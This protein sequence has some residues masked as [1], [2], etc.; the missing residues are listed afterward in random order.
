MEQ[1]PYKLSEGQARTALLTWSL[2]WRPRAGC[3]QTLAAASGSHGHLRHP[4]A[5]ADNRYTQSSPS[6]AMPHPRITPCRR[7]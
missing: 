3:M 4:L 2:A 1:T 5:A 6:S 7:P